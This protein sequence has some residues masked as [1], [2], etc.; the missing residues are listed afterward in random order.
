MSIENIVPIEKILAEQGI[1]MGQFKGVSMRPLL[2][3]GRDTVVIEPL[4]A[5]SPVQEGDIVLYKSDAGRYVLHR[6][7]RHTP[8]KSPEY[9]FLGDNCVTLEPVRADQLLGR[10]TAF[11]RDGRQYTGDELRFRFY[12]LLWC[13]PW[14]ARVM[15]LKVRNRIRKVLRHE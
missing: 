1:Y 3:Q 10:L 5:A 4:S 15:A 7:I 2:Q 6:V 14:Q 13:R 8:G 11:Y 9:T 12:E